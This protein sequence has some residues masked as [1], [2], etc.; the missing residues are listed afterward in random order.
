MIEKIEGQLGACENKDA[1]QLI[2]VFVFPTQ[3][4][5]SL[6]FINLKFQASILTVHVGLCPTCSENHI[7]GFLMTRLKSSHNLAQ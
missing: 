1:D 6:F 3:I 5:Q 4:V 7:I 2:S